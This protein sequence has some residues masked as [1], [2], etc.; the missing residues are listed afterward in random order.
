MFKKLFL[1]IC[2]CCLIQPA[3]AETSY[4]SLHPKIFGSWFSQKLCSKSL[5]LWRSGTFSKYGSL[6][7]V[8]VYK[9]GNFLLGRIDRIN[10]SSILET[11][12]FGNVDDLTLKI[13]IDNQRII[14]A[15]LR[16]ELDYNNR[17]L[18]GYFRSN[19]LDNYFI[20]KL[21]EGSIL[22]I[23]YSRAH[24]SLVEFFSLDGAKQAIDRAMYHATKAERKEA[25]EWGDNASK[26]Q[27]DDGDWGD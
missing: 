5:C 27:Q 2:L 18:I 13:Q 4:V 15:P 10:D 20:Q 23:G 24:G 22:K 7:F 16:R 1:T 17:T 26:P 25:E 19:K 11:W 6:F 8:D 21:Q 3:F 12:R 9:D 14:E